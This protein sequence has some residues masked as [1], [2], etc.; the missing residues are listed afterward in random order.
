M[1]NKIKEIENEIKKEPFTF[2][3]V[4]IGGYFWR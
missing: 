2:A 3:K 1:K 4:K